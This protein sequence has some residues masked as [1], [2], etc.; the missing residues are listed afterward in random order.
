[1]PDAGAAVGAAAA[2]AAELGPPYQART[3]PIDG[4]Q[5]LAAS[6]GVRQ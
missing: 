1:M 3:A 2:A 6:N 5:L 4:Q